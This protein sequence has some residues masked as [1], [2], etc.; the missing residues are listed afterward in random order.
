[1]KRAPNIQ[2]AGRLAARLRFPADEERL[3]WLAMLLDAYAVAD[4]GV[5]VATRETAKRRKAVLACATGCDACC[6]QTDIPLYPHEIVGIYWYAVEKV[7]PPVRDIVLNQLAR[8]APGGACPFLVEHACAIHPLRP[9][10][11]RQFNVF[12]SPCIQGEDP[13]Y[14]RRDDVLEP[15]P[16]YTERVFAAV[17]PFYNLGAP[18]DRAA[19]VKAVRGQIMNLRSYDWKRLAAMMGHAGRGPR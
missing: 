2:P 6:H 4:T 9:L 11:C 13:Y 5:A 8:H 19:A 7:L 16:E 18:T 10:A 14:T 17:I 15:I 3:P 1:M 12:G